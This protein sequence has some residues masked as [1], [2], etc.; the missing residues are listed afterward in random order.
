MSLKVDDRL[1]V[2][3]STFARARV[4]INYFASAV[5]PLGVMASASKHFVITPVCSQGH[6]TSL[7]SK[8]E[9]LEAKVAAEKRRNEELNTAAGALKA[10][11]ATLELEVSSSK[12][13][14]IR[15][16][17]D[18]SCTH[19]AALPV[20]EEIVHVDVSRGTSR[21]RSRT[22]GGPEENGVM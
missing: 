9:N 16:P 14:W 19:S 21:R 6:I 12:V 17:N 20:V 10:H 18:R 5:S 3:L 15:G 8:I 22:V 2:I 11:I 7:Q 1:A 13:R 4:S